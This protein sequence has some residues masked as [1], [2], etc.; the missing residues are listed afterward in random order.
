MGTAAGTGMRLGAQG[1]AAEAGGRRVRATSRWV[2][3]CTKRGVVE[4]VKV[5]RDSQRNGYRWVGGKK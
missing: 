4:R 2:A 3:L 5:E 1:Q